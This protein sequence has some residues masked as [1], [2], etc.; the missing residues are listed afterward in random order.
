MVKNGLETDDN[1]KID[2]VLENYHPEKK[3]DPRTNVEMNRGP[4]II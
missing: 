2:L 3:L 1:F 4:E